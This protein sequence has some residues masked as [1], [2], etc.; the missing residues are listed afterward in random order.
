MPEDKQPLDPSLVRLLVSLLVSQDQKPVTNG[1]TGTRTKKEIPTGAPFSS[2]PFPQ[3]AGLIEE[4]AQAIRPL[5]S[6]KTIAG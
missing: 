6:L 2:E 4:R 1:T 5:V 3:T